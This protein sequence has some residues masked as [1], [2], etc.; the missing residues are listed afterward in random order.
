MGEDTQTK[1]R[2]YRPL[3]PVPQQHEATLLGCHQAALQKEE[4]KEK[5]QSETRAVTLPP[6]PLS[7]FPQQH[8]ATLVERAGAC[9]SGGPQS[10]RRHAPIQRSPG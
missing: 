5:E 4:N 7:P 6:V 3:S 2:R 10:S 1:K 9:A 8:E